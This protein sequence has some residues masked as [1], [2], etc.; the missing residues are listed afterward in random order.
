MSFGNK[1]ESSK[2]REPVDT[3]LYPAV[4]KL[5]DTTLQS[6]NQMRTLSIVDESADL[7]AAVD[8]RVSFTN[9]RRYGLYSITTHKSSELSDINET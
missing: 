4:V 7:S 5:F 9:A 6:L 8:S 2:S 3:R 1:A